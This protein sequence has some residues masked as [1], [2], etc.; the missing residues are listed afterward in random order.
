MKTLMPLL[1]V[2]GLAKA[3][4]GPR[5]LADVAFT[6]ARGEHLAVPGP[7]GCGK[8]TLIRLLVGFDAP[9]A[10]EIDLENR[11]VS[12][13]GRVPVLTRSSSKTA[14]P[15]NKARSPNCSPPRAR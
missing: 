1:A 14:A 15:P 11:A 4:N 5:V 9:D 2:R 7:S 8:T 13:G 6:L 12:R 3:F 10:G